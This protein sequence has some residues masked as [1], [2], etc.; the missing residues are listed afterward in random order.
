[1]CGVLATCGHFSTSLKAQTI[2]GTLMERDSETPIHLGFVA[3]LTESGD[4]VT[5]TITNREG[6]FSLTSPDPG[7]FLLLAA[8][9]GHR[10]TTVGVFELGKDGELTVEF[11]V[12]AEALTMDGLFVQAERIG[13]EP[14]LALNGFSRRMQ[15]GLGYF[16]TPRDIENSDVTRTTDLF[17]GM[18]GVSVIGDRVYV[19]GTLGIC[20]P[21]IY[22]D[23]LPQSMGAGFPLDFIVPFEALAAVEVYRR[24]AEVPLQ[25]GGTGAGCGVILFWTKTGA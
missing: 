7:N 24:A 3:L 6:R 10:E 21:Q 18:L 23:G 25:Y 12:P 22:V 5:S 14:A 1:M 19:R 13:Q 16:M 8:A 9:L 11:R 4:S 17:F 20:S 15:E 2:R